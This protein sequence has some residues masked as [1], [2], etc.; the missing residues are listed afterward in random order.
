MQPLEKPRRTSPWHAL[1]AIALGLLL[2]NRSGG[3][4]SYWLVPEI[5]R[6]ELNWLEYAQKIPR[7]LQID[8]PP[9]I[10]NTILH[11][12]LAGAIIGALTAYALYHTYQKRKKPCTENTTRQTSLKH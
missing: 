11:A 10:R 3:M 8:F 4:T 12:K 2:G 1:L 9:G 6:L 7:L 5:M